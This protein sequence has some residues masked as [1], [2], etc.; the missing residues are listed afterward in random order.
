ME[1]GQEGGVRWAACKGPAP[2]HSSGRHVTAEEVV[3]W[4]GQLE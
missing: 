2:R 1:I 3:S 4:K